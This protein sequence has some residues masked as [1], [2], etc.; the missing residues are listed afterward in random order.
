MVKKGVIIAIIVA[1]IILVFGTAMAIP[2]LIGGS[3]IDQTCGNGVQDEGEDEFTCAED[4]D[5]DESG[6]GDNIC[7]E[8]ETQ[9]NCPGDCGV[10]FSCGNAKCDNTESRQSCPEDCGLQDTSCGNGICEIT[11]DNN[12][13]D[14]CPQDCQVLCGDGICSEGESCSI[15]CSVEEK[16]LQEYEFMR[17]AAGIEDKYLEKEFD[18]DYDAPSMQALINGARDE[19]S[20]KEAAKNIGKKVY[21]DVSYNA[22]LSS[23]RECLSAKASEVLNRGWGWC[24]TMSKVDIAALRG[25]GIAA[26]P[27]QGCLTFKESCARFAVLQGILLPKTSPIKVEDGKYV[28]GGGLHAWVE[29]W[30]PGEGW[31]LMEATNGA[32]LE[33]Q[34]VNY[35]RLKESVKKDR[36]DFCFVDDQVFVQFCSEF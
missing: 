14:T 27:A 30:L 18:Y 32:L 7:G 34:C 11:E 22:D 31:V 9:Q 16:W 6:C 8:G 5:L 10:I 4:F 1:V 29:V 12:E 24:S 28:V 19:G 13:F 21:L 33:T 2:F 35:Q 17:K 3:N 25:L 36:T 20:A 15:D 26:R 23:G